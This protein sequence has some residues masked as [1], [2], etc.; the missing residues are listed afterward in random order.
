MPGNINS[1]FAAR[2]AALRCTTD[3]FVSAAQFNELL[4]LIQAGQ[5][6]S[7]VG[8]EFRTNGQS[9]ALIIPPRT[10]GYTPP[11]FLYQDSLTTYAVGAINMMYVTILP[12]AYAGSSG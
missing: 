3:G 6:T 5:I 10:A 12:N 11:Y 4:L 1:T 7:V 9:R 8:G 2:L